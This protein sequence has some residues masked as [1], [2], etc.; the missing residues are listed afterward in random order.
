MADNKTGAAGRSRQNNPVD[1]TRRS[2]PQFNVDNGV[3]DM[4]SNVPAVEILQKM[5]IPVNLM[6]NASMSKKKSSFQIT[7]VSAM[8][9]SE[10]H[11]G[12]ADSMDDLDETHT[13]DVSSEVLDC[14]KTTDI[15]PDPSSTEETPPMANL[16][17]VVEAIKVDKERSDTTSRFKVVKIASKEPFKRGRW[18]CSDFSDEPSVD[19]DKERANSDV[20]R[21]DDISVPVSE[22]SSAA[23]SVHYVPDQQNEHEEIKDPGMFSLKTD[24]SQMLIDDD[25]DYEHQQRQPSTMVK[26]MPDS[27][28]P[29][30]TDMY[31]QK[32]ITQNAGLMQNNNLNSVSHSVKE[33]TNAPPLIQNVPKPQQSHVAPGNNLKS[34]QLNS[35]SS[36]VPSSSSS[37]PPQSSH[38]MPSQTSGAMSSVPKPG[39]KGNITSDVYT[40]KRLQ[41]STQGAQGKNS[42]PMAQGAP[43]GQSPGNGN[44]AN[45]NGTTSKPEYHQQ[46]GQRD[47]SSNVLLSQ[48]TMTT[49]TVTNSQQTNSA[50]VITSDY[51]MTNSPNM[52]PRIQVTTQSGYES[53][54]GAMGEDTAVA[55]ENIAPKETAKDD[56]MDSYESAEKTQLLLEQMVSSGQGITAALGSPIKDGDGDE[57]DGGSDL[58]LELDLELDP[59]SGSSTVAID[60]KIEQAMDLVK[61]HLMFAVREE[62]EVLREQIKEL[63]EQKAQLEYE[64]SVLKS[65]ALPETLQKLSNG[66]PPQPPTTSAS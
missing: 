53:E 8:K 45:G 37:Q 13:E 31:Q 64:N 55:N 14:S 52:L 10:M 36:N 24:G 63:L 16:G 4:G 18:W 1:Q 30:V 5:G 23:S 49:S 41:D 48:Q 58:N 62:V 33:F 56:P 28:Q 34:D 44:H 47:T 54:S 17:L 21:E 9:H 29:G 35:A 43:P 46:S 59:E 12:D 66:P 2:D 50:S 27:G 6:V 42:S 39:T 25:S 61:S 40:G 51:N 20:K 26:V 57:R 3:N 15:E 19:R 7:S 22:N 65:A 11:E 38:G 32:A 60:N